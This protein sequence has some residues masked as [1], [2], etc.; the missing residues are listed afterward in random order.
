MKTT[1]EIYKYIDNHTT[2]KMHL[3]S[4]NLLLELN[5]IKDEQRFF[6]ELIETYSFQLIVNEKFSGNRKLIENLNIVQNKNEK[7][8]EDL[9]EHENKL[10]VLLTK[11][12]KTINEIKY[13]LWHKNILKDVEEHLSRYKEI[14]LLIFDMI[15]GIMKNEKQKH[16]LEK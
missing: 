9:T 11:S 10:D 12:K 15:K 5:F 2:E 6:E 3:E 4:K 16:L 7:L 8:I 14:K 13:M 1:H